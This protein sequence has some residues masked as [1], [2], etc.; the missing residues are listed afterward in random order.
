MAQTM[1]NSALRIG[2]LINPYAG[3][4]GPAGFKGSDL[5][6]L[7]A[8]AANGQIPLRT[9]ARAHTFW[10]LIEQAYKVCTP[11]LKPVLNYQVLAAPQQMGSDWL[12][13]WGIEHSIID[14]PLGAQSTAQDTQVIAKAMQQQ[15]VDIL[16]FAGGDGTARDIYTAVGSKQLVL[17][18]PCGVKMH[19]GVYA[20]NPQSAAELMI[21]LLS[22]V[23]ISPSLQ[24]VRDI[25][26]NE[27][28]Q[29]RVKARHFGQMPVPQAAEY[30][31]AVKQGGMETE[32]LVLFDIAEYLREKFD[33]SALI[34][35]A[36][37]STTFGLLKEWGFE[38]TLLGVDV[39][40]PTGQLLLDVNAQQ[41]NTC[42]ANHMKTSGD[43]E[44]VLT[45]IGGQGHIIG[46]GNQQFTPPLLKN[47][48]KAHIHVVATKTK[49]RT[50]NGRPLLLDS[51]C[52]QLDNTWAGLIP[53]ITGYNDTVLYP[54]G[55]LP[56]KVTDNSVV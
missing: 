30:M 53:V 28:R 7:Q 37:G 3:I 35:W 16:V 26:E 29:G 38:G 4:G 41:L 48:T 27:F 47:I 51:G 25:D 55:H 8:A 6:A 1:I 9:P 52:A 42:V 49:L 5:P 14:K 23:F 44:L 36:P 39:L 11:K 50:L 33:P 17:G 54:V 32:D 18:I 20:I 31:Q 10:Q 43:I 46:R 12:T 21:Q 40:L 34:I 19:S 13:Q 45:A 24:E 56:K 15:N 2:F 22:G